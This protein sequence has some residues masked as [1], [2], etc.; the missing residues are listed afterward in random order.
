MVDVA[1]DSGSGVKACISNLGLEL[2]EVESLQVG[3]DTSA[4]AHAGRAGCV[5]MG[6]IGLCSPDA[7]FRKAI[8]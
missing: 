4:D 6:T 3:V 2:V 8:D 7:T 5:G 1:I